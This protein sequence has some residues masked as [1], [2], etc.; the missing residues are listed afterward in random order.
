MGKKRGPGALL[1]EWVEGR[2]LTEENTGQ[3]LLE[4]TQSRTADEKSPE[5]RSRGMLGVR[6]AA[7]NDKTQKF[8][9][10]LCHITIDLLRASFFDL[11]RQAAAGVDGETW[12]DYE[13]D[14]EQRIVDLHGRIHRGSYRAKPSLRTYIPKPDG[15]KRP[16]GIPALEDKI[17]QQAVGEVAAA[18]ELVA[19][20]S[21]P[22]YL[23]ASSERRF[24]LNDRA[25]W[26]LP[27]GEGSSF[28]RNHHS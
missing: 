20:A 3:S 12:R 8:T 1:A 26:L 16:L 24:A 10:L 23:A 5:A 17:V 2:G 28:S 25:G 11:K 9:N 7:Q 22:C 27:G 15:R 14:C 21:P 18:S 13:M 19:V 4:R 6:A